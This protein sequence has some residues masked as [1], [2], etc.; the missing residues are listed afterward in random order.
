MRY[1]LTIGH[2]TLLVV[3]SVLATSCLYNP[4]RA[5]QVGASQHEEVER[6]MGLVPD[7]ELNGYVSQIGNKLVAV[8]DK[9]DLG[10]HFVVVDSKDP[11]AFA[12]PGGYVYVTRGLLALANSEDELAGVIAHEIGHVTENHSAS[13]VSLTAPFAIVSGISGWAVGIVS[14]TLGK[15]VSGTTNALA[16]G[17]LI[18]PFSREQERDADRVGQQ[19]A[20][21]AGYDPKGLPDFLDTLGREVELLSGEQARFHFLDSH[22]LTP[23]RVEATKQ[24]APQLQPAPAS[25]VARNRADFLGRIEGIVV[26]DDPAEGVFRENLFLHPEYGLALRFPIGWETVNSRE[27]VGAQAPS[28]DAV[29]VLRFAAAESSVD[30]VVRKVQA[31]DARIEI[32]RLTINGHP[33]ARTRGAHRGSAFEVTWLSLGNDV[34]QLSG[35]GPEESASRYARIFHAALESFRRLT[36]AERRSIRES[37][38]RVHRSRAG[39]T[40]AAIAKRWGSSWEGP[41]VAVVNAVEKDA[42]FG[43]GQLVKLALPEHYTARGR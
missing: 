37:R 7:A 17:L 32:E 21:K 5:A 42:R 15:A 8:S 4:K 16:G 19:L 35:M 27:A 23:D 12:L 34:Y 43:Q 30:D 11:N 38:L 36:P 22:P 25:P 18:A 41:Q 10:F 29:L 9:P 13:R 1:S 3:V 28:N 40:P 2:V 24:R 33:A 26:G 14:P 31:E 6:S 39:E 20:A